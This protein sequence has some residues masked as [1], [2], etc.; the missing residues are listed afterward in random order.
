VTVSPAARAKFATGK[1]DAPKATVIERWGQIS[2]RGQDFGKDD[3]KAD[4]HV[5]RE[6]G[7]HLLGD[8]DVRPG[9][10]APGSPHPGPQERLERG[11]AERAE[12]ARGMI[13]SSP[14]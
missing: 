11:G 6:I 7:L 10:A 1:G 14:R 5:L 8:A 3:N 4:A 13:F 2:G 9:A 12:G